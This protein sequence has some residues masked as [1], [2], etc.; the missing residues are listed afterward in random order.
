VSVP[1]GSGLSGL[2]GALREIERQ[3]R[4]RPDSGEHP[5][6]ATL[7]AYRA[8]TLCPV[9]E[10]GVKEHLA[11]CFDCPELLLDLDL[12][13]APSTEP[14]EDTRI[15][16][17]VAWRRLRASLAK[18]WIPARLLAGLRRLWPVRTVDFLAAAPIAALLLLMLGLGL[19]NLHLQ[20][21]LRKADGAAPVLADE[22]LEAPPVVR[23][24]GGTP[25]SELRLPPGEGRV[26]LT[27]HA[28]TPEAMS[29]FPEYRAEILATDGSASVRVDGLV[30]DLADGSGDLH[31]SVPR[32]LLTAGEHRVRISGLRG[33]RPTMVEEYAVRVVD[34]VPR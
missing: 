5:T 28:S 33:A 2:S 4:R 19:Q 9:D 1:A 7:A 11:L 13:L 16:T 23:G 10:R 25:L 6:P 18:P 32:H 17:E 24:P 29:G 22:E 12:F 3:T 20:R 31:I 8:G 14:G 34:L 26:V 21:D 27:L 15:E 30:P